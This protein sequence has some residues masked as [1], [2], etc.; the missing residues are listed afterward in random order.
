M[1][2][3]LLARLPELGRLNRR[4]VAALVR[5]AALVG[6]APRQNEAASSAAWR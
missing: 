4:E 6:V 2:A 1:N 3:S 5:V